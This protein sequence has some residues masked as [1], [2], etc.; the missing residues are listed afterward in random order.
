MK[1][2]I[3]HNINYSSKKITEFECLA[4]IFFGAHQQSIHTHSPASRYIFLF[5]SE[6][7]KN[8]KDTAAI[9]ANLDFQDFNN[10]KILKICQ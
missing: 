9:G 6:N 2:S 4:V 5:F 10:L 8:K 3:L 1:Y 7:E